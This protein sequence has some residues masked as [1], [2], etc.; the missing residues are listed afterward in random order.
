MSVVLIVGAGP[1]GLTLACE[2]AVRGVAFRLIDAAAGPFAGSRAKGVQP[3]T[4]EV[5]DRLGCVEEIVAGGLIGL[6]FR[7]HGANGEFRDVPRPVPESRPDV[8][9]PAPVLIPQWRTEAALRARLEALGGEVEYGTAL[10]D[11]AENGHVVRARLRRADT[12]DEIEATWL[13]GCDGGRSTVRRLAGLGFLGETHEDMRMLVGDLQVEGIDREHWHVWRPEG[14]GFLA[15]APLAGSEAFQVQIG[16][17]PNAPLDSAEAPTLASFQPLVE[18]YTGR[19]DIRLSQPT[20]TSLWRANVRMV[21]RYRAGRLLVA[22]DAAHVHTP[23]GG[24]GMNTGIQDAFNLGWKLA[25]VERGAPAALLDSY[26]AERLP[27]AREVLDLSTRLVATT[28]SPKTEGLV[29]RSE[30][31]T[32]LGIRYRESPLS[33]ERRAAPAGALRAGDRAPDATALL[34][35]AGRSWRLFDLLR[36]PY[37][38]LLAFGAGWEALLDAG[39]AAASGSA[40][41]VHAL[42]VLAAGESTEEGGL[43]TLVDSRG[44]AGAAWLARKGEGEGALFAI[45]PDG[46]IG[47]ATDHRRDAEALITWL[48]QAGLAH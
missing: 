16:I 1:T 47:F 31:T 28:L 39:L 17:G 18:R 4:L 34:D 3:R 36:G 7:Q 13:V 12:I 24:Q 21:E 33:H 9:W 2:L 25:A 10:V 6:P 42:R 30:D 48:R 43:R 29:A 27:V 19:S 20:W 46:V 8:P 22:G 41:G 32:Q 26:E 11:A 37:A 35:R 45:R 15:M 23:A 40:G 38:T 14:G 44:H 5:F